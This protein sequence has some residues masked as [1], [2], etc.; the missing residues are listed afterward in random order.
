MS[1]LALCLVAI[2][3]FSFLPAS[4]GAVTW[5]LQDVVFANG[6]TATGTFDYDGSGNF[7]NVNITASG[8]GLAAPLSFTSI[9]IDSSDLYLGALQDSSPVGDI[10]LNL[11]F[12]SGLGNGPGPVGLRTGTGFDGLL[13][14]DG[15]GVNDC[16]IV[17]GFSTV[18]SGAAIVSPVPLP[19]ALPLL[20]GGLGLIGLM[21]WRRK[22]RAAA[23]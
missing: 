20:A 19:A 13:I 7:S 14:C 23:S 4:A 22:R 2:F 1:R 16:G 10:I 11:V 6:E 21:G 9:D 15:G 18:V 3:T 12:P 17:T 5:S 8:G